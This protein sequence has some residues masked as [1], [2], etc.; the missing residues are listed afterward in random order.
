MES[1]QRFQ[2]TEET[3]A[4]TSIVFTKNYFIGNIALVVNL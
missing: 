3:T 2:P 1:S 4:Q